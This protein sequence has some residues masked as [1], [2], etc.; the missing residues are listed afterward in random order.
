VSNHENLT[1]WRMIEMYLIMPPSL[2]LLEIHF[3]KVMDLF[4]NM[5]NLHNNFPGKDVKFRG[6]EGNS[7]R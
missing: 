2:A 7:D 4:F 3:F 5:T 6:R 1:T